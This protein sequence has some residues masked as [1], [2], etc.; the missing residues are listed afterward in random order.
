PCIG[1]DRELLTLEATLEEVERE[2]IARAV[3][4]TAEAGVGKSRLRRE[5]LHRVRERGELRVWIARADPLDS[6]APHGLLGQAVRRALAIADDEPQK[7]KQS[8]LRD[9]LARVLPDPAALERVW[10][11]AAEIIGAPLL[12]NTSR[13][14]A[15]ARGDRAL[16]AD[17][18]RLAFEEWIVAECKEPLLIVL[19]DAHWSD[20]ATLRLLDAALGAAADH[21]LMVA[22][23]ARPPLR[24]A[25]PRLFA[26]RRAQ[27]LRLEELSKRSAERLARAILGQEVPQAVVA[28]VVELSNGNAF[29]LEE[30]VRAVK[31]GKGELP[32]SVLSVV[33]AR[34]EALEPDARRVLRAA[35]VFGQ[36]FWPSGVAAVLGDTDEDAASAWIATLARR[37]IVAPRGQSRFEH[38][39]ELT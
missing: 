11:F 12:A 13:S 23:F 10:P 22:V 28:R 20:A 26:E 15:A 38:E 1:R 31:D 33:E 14:L 4:V 18:L 2:R 37:E 36:F 3:V 24:E 7:A 32:E 5:W 29:F 27:E 19:D 17:R 9:H 16:M 6:R 25:H 34:L 39:A 8:R 30:L 35:S 21:P